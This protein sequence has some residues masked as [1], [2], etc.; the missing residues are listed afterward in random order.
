MVVFVQILDLIVS[1]GVVSFS[2][3]STLDASKHIK[4]T[5][6]GSEPTNQP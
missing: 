2:T 1:S 3:L 6:E 4:F 5:T